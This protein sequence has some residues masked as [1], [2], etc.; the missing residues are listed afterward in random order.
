M[1]EDFKIGLLGDERTERKDDNAALAVA[2]EFLTHLIEGSVEKKLLAPESQEKVADSLTFGLKQGNTPIS[3][4]LG[5]PRSRADGELAASVRLFGPIGTTEGMIYIAASGSQWCVAD[6]QLT[7][8]QLSVKREKS[9]EK[10]FPLE[11]R[12]LLEE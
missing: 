10:F 11:Y 8:A 7:L 5:A 1:P 3:F 9:K 12:W 2:E 6:L 4:R